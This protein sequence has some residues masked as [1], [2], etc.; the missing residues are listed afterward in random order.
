MKWVK[1]ILLS[2]LVLI[3][4]VVGISFFLP[5]TSHIER[6]AVINAKPE[7]VF[8]F[9]NN[10]KTYDSWMTWNQMDPDWKVKMS[11]NTTGKGATYSWE[12]DNSDVGKGS[13]TITESKPNTTVV[14]DLT[15]DGMGTS[16]IA[17]NLTPDGAGTKVQWEMNSDMSK[18]PFIFSVMGKWMSAL[19]VMDKMAGGEFDKSLA[20]LKKL[21]ETP[22]TVQNNGGN[23]SNVTGTM[24]IEEKD[25]APAI[26][27]TKIGKAN[28][29]DEIGPQLGAIYQAV[30]ACAT[31]NGLKMPSAPIASYKSQSSPY[32][33]WGGMIVD[34]APAKSC[35]GIVVRNLGAKH[36][37][38]GHFYGPYT[39]L[40]TGYAELEKWI[41]DHGKTSDGTSIEQ[42]MNDPTTVKPEEILTDIIWPIK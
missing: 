7:T 40:A 31:S 8:S 27:L 33:F 20:N 18:A 38:V 34:K 12:S 2:L 13:M 41:K 42:Y 16:P 37:V 10:L 32:E 1:R 21:A 3:V 25:F 24:T 22:G 23:A 17:F 9:I 6:S 19:G 35:D 30:G 39:Q 28:T 26:I 4:L 11:E 36:V 14:S 15:V 5:K 29:I